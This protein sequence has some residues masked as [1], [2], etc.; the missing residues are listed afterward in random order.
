MLQR[1]ARSKVLE[2][3]RGERTQKS[4]QRVLFCLEQ[5][6]MS[7]VRERKIE[8]TGDSVGGIAEKQRGL[9]HGG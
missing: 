2:K 8:N 4:S 9:F 7:I 6:M 3:A 5:G 1:D